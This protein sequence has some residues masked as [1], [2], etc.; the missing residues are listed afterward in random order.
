MKPSFAGAGSPCADRSGTDSRRRKA[1][2]GFISRSGIR[3]TAIPKSW[4]GTPRV[5]RR[6]MF[7]GVRTARS[8]MA[9]ARTRSTAI[10]AAELPAPMTSTLCPAYGV[11]LR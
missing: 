10:S 4:L 2:S 6:T 8:T 9:P 11:A 1:E 7:G 5:S 3:F